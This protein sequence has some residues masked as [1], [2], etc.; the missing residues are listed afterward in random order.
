MIV[1]VTVAQSQSVYQN[2]PCS[3]TVTFWPVSQVLPGDMWL[4]HGEI[5][6][7]PGV[8]QFSESSPR[9]TNVLNNTW[10]FE[11]FFWTR[12]RL[13]CVATCNFTHVPSQT[14]LCPIFEKKYTFY[15]EI[16]KNK[17][18]SA[19]VFSVG[20]FICVF[21]VKICARNPRGFSFFFLHRCP[22]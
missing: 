14:D 4:S 18:K 17:G 10:Y 5:I 7:L 8:T 19:C 22:Y 1:H 21:V 15:L 2:E 16:H 13:T 6:M 9:K 12:P 11:I 20:A 3:P